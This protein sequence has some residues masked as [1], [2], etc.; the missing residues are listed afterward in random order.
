M[1]EETQLIQEPSASEKAL[2]T[3]ALNL[4][5]KHHE[6]T[7][8]V[9]QLIKAAGI[10]KAIFYKH[11]AN[12]EDVYAAILLNDELSLT[13]LLKDLRVYGTLSDLLEQYLKFRIQHVEK[14]RV[15]VRLEK[16][17]LEKECDQ[18]R[19]K[20]WQALRRQHVDEFTT[21]VE[22]KLSRLKP[23]DKENTR[24]YY[25]LVWSIANGMV[26]LSES[27][28]F[29]ELVLDRRGF[30]KFLLDSVAQIGDVR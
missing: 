25:G 20:Q 4:F 5:I 16:H 18:A 11:F 29:H 1:M 12:K 22:N 26:N 15:I 10:S 28:F 14:Y 24:F 23:I 8:N 21:I 27:D 17:L 19:F 2:V 7:I 30:T 3:S 6:S 13:P 9:T